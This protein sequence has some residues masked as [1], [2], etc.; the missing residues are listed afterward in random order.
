MQTYQKQFAELQQQY[1]DYPRHVH[2]ETNSFCNAR[3]SFCPQLTMARRNRKMPASIFRK[4]IKDLREVPSSHPLTIYPYRMNE[5]LTDSR[6]FEFL[7]YTN[8]QLPDAN[9]Y[10]TSNFNL[11]SLDTFEN[12]MTLKNVST[13]QIS[14]HSFDP[15]EYQQH[16]GLTLDRTLAAIRALLRLPNIF[17]VT[18]R[19]RIIR[20]G[21]SSPKDA[22]FA[23]DADRFLSSVGDVNRQKVEIVVGGRMDWLG[24]LKSS[25]KLPLDLPCCKWFEIG[26]DCNGIVPLC[27]VDWDG[28]RQ[29]GNVKNQSVLEIY[30]QSW[31][32]NL[33][34]KGLLRKNI[35]PCDCCSYG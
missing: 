29:L 18:K 12:L 23:K 24:Y 32:R 15:G 2:I 1:M 16:M 26:F 25:C 21:D 7:R 30:N 34:L 8:K 27:C 35:T 3:C 13:I 6:I 5:L 14:L 19:I 20:I 28:R 4:I 9:L 33:R 31:Y 10:L 11:A 17:H 22:Q